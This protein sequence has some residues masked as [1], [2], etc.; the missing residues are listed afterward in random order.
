MYWESLDEF[1]S[2]SIILPNAQIPVNTELKYE[3]PQPKI[4]LEQEPDYPF[5]QD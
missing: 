1:P 2:Q 5:E 3:T 4:P